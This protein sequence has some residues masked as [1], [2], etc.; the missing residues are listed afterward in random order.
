MK[1]IRLAAAVVLLPA[2]AAADPGHW[3]TVAG[4]DHWLALGALVLAGAL[5]AAALARGRKVDEAE[6]AAEDAAD[7]EAEA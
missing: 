1:P 5:A 7:G 3:G 2:A 6:A 4:H